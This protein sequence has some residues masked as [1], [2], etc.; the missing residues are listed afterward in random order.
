M[1][2]SSIPTSDQIEDL[3]LAVSMMTHEQR[4]AFVASIALKYCDGSYA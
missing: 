4:R 2:T 3:R 1:T